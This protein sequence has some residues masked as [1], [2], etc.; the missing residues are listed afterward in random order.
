MPQYVALI[1]GEDADWSDPVHAEQS[2]EYGEFGEPP[3]LASCEAAAPCSRPAPPPRCA[4]KAARAATSS[5]ATGP[6]PRPRRSSAAST[7]SSAPTSTRRIAWAAQI[8][9]AW[10]GAVEVRPVIE[11]GVTDGSTRSPRPSGSR[12]GES[13]ATLTRTLGDLDLAEDAVQDAAV[14]A[15]ESW[16]RD[17]VPDDPAPGSPSSPATGRSTALRREAKRTGKEA[18]TVRPVRR[19]PDARPRLRRRATTSCG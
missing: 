19:R 13:L 10:T 12:A 18:A 8:P 15:L 1:Y 2:A 11:F 14:A 4:C 7:C 6:S 5:P 3:P 17:G 16:P 9:G